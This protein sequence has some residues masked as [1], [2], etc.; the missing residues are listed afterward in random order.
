[1][2]VFFQPFFLHTCKPAISR[3]HVAADSRHRDLKPDNIMLVPDQL[4]P[5]GEGAKILDLGIAKPA[6]D[7]KSTQARTR[8]DIIIGTPS[9][10]SPEQCR[11]AGVVDARPRL[12]PAPW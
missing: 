4:V 12:R 10:M 9:Y 6:A 7:A 2:K 8:T 5:G 1:M 11:E 3:R